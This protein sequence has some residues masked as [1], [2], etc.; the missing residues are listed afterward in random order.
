MEVKKTIGTKH[1]IPPF[2]PDRAVRFESET[3]KPIAQD[4]L[5]HV[6][7][8]SSFAWG[9]HLTGYNANVTHRVNALAHHT[10]R[11]LKHQTS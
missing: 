10:F 2:Q 7:N 9:K 5:K 6:Q 8:P 3:I 11:P 4:T 1:V